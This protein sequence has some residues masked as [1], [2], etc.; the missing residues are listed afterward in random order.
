M[1]NPHPSRR[2]TLN[3]LVAALMTAGLAA[4]G[5]TGTAAA[6]S[7]AGSE[8][9]SAAIPLAT[10]VPATTALAPVPNADSTSSQMITVSATSSSATRATLTAWQKNSKGQWTVAIG[11]VSAWVGDAG[12]GQAREGSSK[13]PQGTWTLP[14]A[15]GRQ[16]DP[17]TALP[18]FTTDTLDWWDGDVDSSTY[19]THVRSSANLGGASENLYNAGAVYNYAV[20]IGYNLERTPGGGSAFFLHV[21]GGEPTGGCVAIP[22]DSLVRILQ[23]IKPSAK[24]VIRI[25]LDVAKPKDAPQVQ[26][27]REGDF[28][29][30]ATT[31]QVFRVIGGAPI[32][33]TTWDAYGGRQP[34]RVVSSAAIKALPTYPRTGTFVKVR[35]NGNIYRIIGGAPIPVTSWRYFGGAKSTL[36][37]DE[38]AIARA[39]SGGSWNHLRVVPADGV[40]LR[41]LTTGRLYRTAGGAPIFLTRTGAVPDAST[42]VLVDPTTI[43]NGGKAGKW[44]HLR[45]VPANGTFLVGTASGSVYR[46]SGGVPQ[47]I[48]SWAPYGGRQPFTYV[49]QVAIDRAGR[50][51]P[52]NHLR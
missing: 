44:R 43:A 39:G 21:S 3:G 46:V 16:P 37:I 4:G 2:R 12:I 28:L 35:S 6:S 7:P 47:R 19:N 51:A 8:V 14:Q 24:P 42:P 38:T 29:Q 31:K 5:L 26:P 1:L 33:V 27:I 40:V 34:T 48:T 52:W 22:S 10:T 25:G 41:D 11:P 18:Y 32:P 17:G 15:F 30:S 49:D 50:P 45:Y 13:T 20:E 23:W 9:R 36:T